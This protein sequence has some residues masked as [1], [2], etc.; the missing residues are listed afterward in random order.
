MQVQ[1]IRSYS[2]FL[3][4][5][6]DWERM[7][8]RAPA[9]NIFLTHDWLA[10]WWRH[11]GNGNRIYILAV[12]EAKELIGLAPLMIQERRLAGFPVLRRIAFLGTGVSDRLDILLA[13]GQE[14]AILAA[15]I[16]HLQHERWNVVDLEEIS[17]QSVTTKLLPPLAEALGIRVEVS[18]QSVCPVIELCSD[19]E[20]Y[21]T[22]LNRKIRK[23]LSYY[24]RRIMKERAV[25]VDSVTGPQLDRDL[26]AFFQIYRKSLS[27]RAGTRKLVGDKFEVFRKEVA[28]RFAQQDRVHLTLLHVDGHAV[29]GE[30]NFVYRGT[31]YAYNGCHDP[32]WN[33]ESVGTVL[34]WEVIRQAIAAGCH[35]YDFL[36][37]EERYKYRWGAKPRP[38]VQIRLIRETPG[39]RILFKCARLLR[40][41]PRRHPLKA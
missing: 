15:I 17:E 4:M 7:M 19:A 38:H 12:Y 25:S 39:L 13:K 21:L 35:E 28:M 3:A 41:R 9:A 23:N 30:L 5:R 6:E 10:T 40:S 14:R 22:S 2:E 8:E 36:R 26:Q 32:D 29:A 20:S 33:Q 37:G 34:Q 1:A 24:Q 11:Y 27:G 16:S 31:Y 18:V